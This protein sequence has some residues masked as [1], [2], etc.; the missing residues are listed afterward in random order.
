VFAPV[1]QELNSVVGLDIGFSSTHLSELGHEGSNLSLILMRA[2]LY[3]LKQ[4]RVKYYKLK[5]GQLD[6]SLADSEMGGA[7]SS[8]S[9]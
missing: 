4:L 2:P 8:R 9:R 3:P 1:K 5:V 6:N 7:C